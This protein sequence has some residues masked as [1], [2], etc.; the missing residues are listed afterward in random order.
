MKL[1]VLEVAEEE[2]QELLHILLT[3]YIGKLRV[4]DSKGRGM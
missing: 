3:I 4:H 1:E 2:A